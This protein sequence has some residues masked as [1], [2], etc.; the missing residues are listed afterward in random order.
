MLAFSPIS[1]STWAQSNTDGHIPP[2]DL[3][4]LQEVSIK[5]EKI[6]FQLRINLFFVS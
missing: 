4:G 5:K 2:C 6:G 3:K 1:V